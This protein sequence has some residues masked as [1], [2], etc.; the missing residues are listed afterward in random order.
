MIYFLIQTGIKKKKMPEQ[1]EQRDSEAEVAGNVY[2][3]FV[4]GQVNNVRKEFSEELHLLKSQVGSCKAE[5][6]KLTNH[7][8]LLIVSLLDQV[9]LRFAV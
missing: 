5:I 4:S 8:D 6:E 3:E 7:K 1:P 2:V 9:R